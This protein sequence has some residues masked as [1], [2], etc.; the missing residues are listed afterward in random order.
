MNHEGDQDI[1]GMPGSLEDAI[2]NATIKKRS[3]GRFNDTHELLD[4]YSSGDHFAQWLWLSSVR[5]LAIGI[6]SITNVLSPEC[7]ILAGGI[8][9]TGNNL[10]EPLEC[11]LSLYEWRAGGNKTEIIKAQFG[12]LAGA[13]GAACY[14]M[15]NSAT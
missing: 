8:T 7:I 15:E 9:E 11:F 3:L 13:T 4:A 1:T 12:D 5:K 6:A 14:A 10:F 2:G